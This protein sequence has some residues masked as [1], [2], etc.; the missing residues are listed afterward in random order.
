MWKNWVFQILLFLKKFI[1]TNFKINCWST[2]SNV[3]NKS[4]TIFIIFFGIVLLTTFSHLQKLIFLF[5]LPFISLFFFGNYYLLPRRLLLHPQKFLINHVYPVLHPE[6]SSIKKF[7]CFFLEY[8]TKFMFRYP[9]MIKQTA[10]QSK[11]YLLQSHTF[12]FTCIYHWFVYPVFAS[13]GSY[14]KF[15]QLP[16]KGFRFSFYLSCFRKKLTNFFLARL[17]KVFCWYCTI[18]FYYI[19]WLNILLK[20]YCLWLEYF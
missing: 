13:R 15:F 10:K 12:F 14:C 4:F 7:C 1:K 9:M 8:H 19:T 16:V 18:L 2:N 5:L 11:K 6:N 3:F 20:S 17:S